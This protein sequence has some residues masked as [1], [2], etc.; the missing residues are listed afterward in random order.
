[1]KAHLKLE[2]RPAANRENMICGENYRITVLTESL[3]RMEYDP[4]GSFT[5]EAT[6]TVLNRDFPKVDFI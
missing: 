3:V 1:M 2:A 6:Q 4:E 5:D